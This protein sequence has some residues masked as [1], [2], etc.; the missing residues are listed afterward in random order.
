MGGAL[1]LGVHANESMIKR[2]MPSNM[3]EEEPVVGASGHSTRT[4]WQHGVGN[5]DVPFN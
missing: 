2:V 3:Q 5:A 1:S 4:A